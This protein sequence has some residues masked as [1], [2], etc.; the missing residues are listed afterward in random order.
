MTAVNAE[1]IW[2]ETGNAKL[3]LKKNVGAADFFETP[4]SIKS[5]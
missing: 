2:L 4:H 5:L 1:L 3:R